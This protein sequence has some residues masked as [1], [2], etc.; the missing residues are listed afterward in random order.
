MSDVV[1]ITGASGG[2]GRALAIE[3]VGR[4]CTVVGLGRRSDALDETK[5]LAG[6][7][8]HPV[9]T[10]IADAGAV[11]RAFAVADTLGPL[12]ILI[13]NAAVYPRRDILEET[14]A[15]FM[16]TVAVNL[17]G[18]VAASQMALARFVATGTGRIL[19][20]STFADI[21]PLPG[22]AAYSVS[23]GAQRILT[24]ALVADIADRF[25]DIVI[26]DWMPGMLATEM[27]IP[28]GIAPAQAATW[29]A[30]LALWH[31]RSIS[32]TTWEENREIP[33]PRGLKSRIKDK[34]LMRKAVVRTLASDGS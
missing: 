3:M 28:D 12:T 26:N 22:S 21:A 2:L 33:A 14:P 31:D 32:G 20:V 19:N 27:G 8:F 16:E 6:D 17:G 5:A 18:P 7:Q 29:G 15:S 1:M 30:T 34:V 4:G 25:P 24:R 13:N 10:D 9:V 23:K 11:E